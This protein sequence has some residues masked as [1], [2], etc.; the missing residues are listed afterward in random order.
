MRA[1]LAALLIIVLAAGVMAG[2][3]NDVA[4]QEVIRI[5]C[6]TK[7][8]FPTILATVA[9]DKG[10]F[11][12]EGLKP[13]IT[14]YRGGGET[15]E[16]IAAGS[17]D[18]GTVAVPLIATSR[19]RGVLTKI[20]G[21]SG[22]EWSGWILGV[23]T[24]SPVK[25]AKEL[26]GKK[27]G[28]TSA[29]SGTDTLALWAQS[30]HKVTFSRI[31]VGGGGLVPNLLNNNLAAAVIYSPLSYQVVSEGKVRP[32]I[33]FATAMPPNLIGGWTATEKNLT[34]RRTV[35]QKGLNALYGAL[36]YMR[37]NPDYAIKTIA[38]NNE[39]APAIAKMEFERTF[40]RLSRDGQT[41]LAAVEKALELAA[42]SGVKDMAPA[43]E[44][45]QNMPIVPT[46]P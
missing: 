35:I 20:V 15:F 1:T 19:K 44:V 13:E 17:A 16:A 5:G 28:I 39:L 46:K 12:K 27:V 21:G 11:E 34:D 4:A 26:D 3:S 33:D 30:E 6:P 45:F 8:Y 18:L 2:L 43:V 40:L 31:G 14:I 29:G 23:K 42:A 24:D 22:D 7:T 32:L 38:E 10:L 41:K 36:E 9:K 25:S 37:N